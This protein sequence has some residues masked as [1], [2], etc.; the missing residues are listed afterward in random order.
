MDVGL[1]IHIP[2]CRRKC[3][4]CDFF[5][6]PIRPELAEA[7]VPALL[8]E[9]RL[10]FDPSSMRM[11][12]IFIGGGTP[13]ILPE[14]LLRKLL[15]ETIDWVKP[16]EQVEFTVEANPETFHESTVELLC[17]SGVNRL[18]LG[19][20]S[21]HQPELDIL[22]RTHDP[23]DVIRSV[24]LFR[25]AGIPHLNLDLI[26]GI[27]GQTLTT[28]LDSLRRAIALAPD[29]VSCYGLTYESGTLLHRRRAAGSIRPVAEDAEADM[30]LKAIDRLDETGFARYEISNFAQPGAQCRHNIRYWHQEP[31]IGIGPSASSY[32]DGRR[33]KNVPDVQEYVRILSRNEKPVMEAE[34]L[35][36]RR[37][38]GE[39]AMLL[40]RTAGGIQS[41][42]FEEKTGFDPS[43]LFADTIQQHQ[44]AGLLEMSGDGIRLAREGLLLADTVLADFMLIDE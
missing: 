17:A 29:H 7:L 44:R 34:R 3:G 40:L 31:V 5:S 4:Y 42:E 14:P 41:R 19:V 24:R 23:E 32:L 10:T 21:F 36:P 43:S 25:E 8:H 33:W 15:H 27:P 1:Y 11:A 20:Q 35:S 2:F 30:Y 38:A 22:D 9:L 39:L 26:F 28:W 13:T 37:R 6:Q 18:S 12:T 16:N